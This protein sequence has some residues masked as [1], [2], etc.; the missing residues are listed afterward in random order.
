MAAK[1]FLRSK[2]VLASLGINI[3]IAQEWKLLRCLDVSHL[4]DEAFGEDDIDLFQ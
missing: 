2:P 4:L 3:R 1:L